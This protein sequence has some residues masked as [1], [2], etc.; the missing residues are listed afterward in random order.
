MPVSD[1]TVAAE[2]ETQTGSSTKPKVGFVSLGCPKNLVDSEVM[3]GMLSQAGAEL[4]ANAEEA[5]VIVVNT[6]SFIESAQQESVNAILEMARLKGDRRA[7]KLVVAGCLVE[8]FRDEIRKNIPEVD[9]V[10]GTGELDQIV[11][12]AGIATSGAP[13]SPFKILTSRPEGAAREA[14][15]RF[16]RESWDGAIADLPNYLYDDATPRV[17][18]TP[19]YSAYIKIAEGCDHPCSFCIIPQI[20]GKFRSRRFES[21][22]AEAERLAQS[23]VREITLI[24]QDTTCYGEDFDLKDGLALL[25]EKLARIQDLRWIRFL[26]AYPNKIT[27]RLLETIAANNKI[28][29]YIDVPLQHASASVLK[30]MKRGGGADVFLRSIEKMRRTISDLTLRTSFIVGFP[31]ETE[32]EFQELCDFVQEARFDWL[33]CFGYS[34]QEGAGAFSL[35]RKISGSEIERRR[36]HLMKIQQGISKKKLRTHVGKEFEVLLEGPSAESELLLE[37]RTQMHAP[38]IDGKIYI[39]DVAADTAIQPG[40]FYRCAITEA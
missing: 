11:G 13:D 39:N 3:M 40:Q 9:A 35:E 25:L 36:K 2:N 38:E 28:C 12:A 8:R 20:R 7:R 4:T 18:T 5:D 19:A 14:Q 33:G 32:R 23:G 26:Y 21:V 22:I 16:S 17:L 1:T 27:G 6:C 37:G 15:G 10:V 24:G 34:D 30:R 31:G 29:P